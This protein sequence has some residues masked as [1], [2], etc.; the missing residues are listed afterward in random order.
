[1]NGDPTLR[2]TSSRITTLAIIHGLYLLITGIW[3]IIHMESFVAITGPKE[4]YWLVR[5]V[6]MLVFFIGLG[7]LIAGIKKH[8]PFS[9]I[10]I[11][12]GSALGFIL[13]NVTYVW[14]GIIPWVYLLDVGIEL[15]LLLSWIVLTYQSGEYE[16]FHE[17]QP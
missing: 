16:L 7:L 3:P 1:M 12:G 9:L 13:I 15:V 14:Q 2:H 17:R 8:V 11:A 4:D 5:T 6:G 10:F